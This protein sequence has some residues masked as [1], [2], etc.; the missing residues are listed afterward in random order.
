VAKIKLDAYRCE[1]CEHVWVPRVYHEDNDHV[2]YRK[3]KSSYWNKRKPESE[4]GK[5][6]MH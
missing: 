4:G 3:C 1:R 5:T 6:V 2:I